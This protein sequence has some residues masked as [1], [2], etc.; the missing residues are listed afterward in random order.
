MERMKLSEWEI[1]VMR[2][3]FEDGNSKPK[4]KE[5]AVAYYEALHLNPL[6]SIN[7]DRFLYDMYQ[8]IVNSYD[9]KELTVE[10]YVRSVLW[11]HLHE[12]RE[13]LAII[14]QRESDKSSE[15]EDKNK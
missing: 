9:N 15:K 10:D 14:M 6:K 12:N 7:M 2:M 3:Y 13:L 8:K 5:L 11:N 1:N 4:K